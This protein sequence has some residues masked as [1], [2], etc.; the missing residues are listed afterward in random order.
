MLDKEGV[1][2]LKESVKAIQDNKLGNNYYMSPTI[3]ELETLFKNS[4]MH[5]M[6][7]GELEY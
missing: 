6:K 5:H 1:F 4:G 3:N 2:L 7:V